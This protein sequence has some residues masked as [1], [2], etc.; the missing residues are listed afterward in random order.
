[1]GDTSCRRDVLAFLSRLEQR[2]YAKPLGDRLHLGA[3][4]HHNAV[5]ARRGCPHCSLSIPERESSARL[6]IKDCAQP[7][8]G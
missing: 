5:I 3:A 8:F 4:G 6:W 1:M 2:F 7:L